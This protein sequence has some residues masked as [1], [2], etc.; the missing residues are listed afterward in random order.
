MEGERIQMGVTT[1]YVTQDVALDMA[2]D[3]AKKAGG[4]RRVAEELFVSRQYVDV[5]L[6]GTKPLSPALQKLIGVKKIVMYEIER[7]TP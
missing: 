2:R 4:P 1:Q 5:M 6:A 7:R 3:Y